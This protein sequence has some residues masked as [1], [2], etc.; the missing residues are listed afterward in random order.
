VEASAGKTGAL[1]CVME[2]CSII[3]MNGSVVQV[4]AWLGKEGF[5]EYVKVFEANKIRLQALS[6]Q[7]AV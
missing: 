6:Q 7:A 4:A 1:F 5:G 2:R 3:I